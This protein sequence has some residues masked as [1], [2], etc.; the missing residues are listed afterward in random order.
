M[1][2]D[3]LDLV[4]NRRAKFADPSLVPPVKDKND[5]SNIIKEVN[6]KKEEDKKKLAKKVSKT[7]R[8]IFSNNEI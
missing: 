6:R 5:V 3:K 8:S 7:A 4:H 1:V 2:Q